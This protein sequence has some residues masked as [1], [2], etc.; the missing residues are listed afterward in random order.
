MQYYSAI[1]KNETVPF[2]AT[3]MDREILIRSEVR[4]SKKKIT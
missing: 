4:Q 1:K 2:I 3:R